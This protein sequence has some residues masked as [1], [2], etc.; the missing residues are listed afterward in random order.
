M[1]SVV[2]TIKH[3]IARLSP[4]VITVVMVVVRRESFRVK[5]P[6]PHHSVWGDLSV[7]KMVCV[8]TLPGVVHSM[9]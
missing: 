8:V 4:V 7:T 9:V 1:E 2:V 6:G 5:V 3:R